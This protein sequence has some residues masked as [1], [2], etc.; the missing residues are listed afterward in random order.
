MQ[1]IRTYGSDPQSLRYGVRVQRD[2]ASRPS[3][4]YFASEGDREAWLDENDVDVL[5]YSEP[6]VAILT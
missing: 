6:R 5:S 3:E 4:V 2:R 1:R